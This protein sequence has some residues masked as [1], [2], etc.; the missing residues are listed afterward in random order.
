[1]EIESFVSYIKKKRDFSF[2]T[3]TF[4]RDFLIDYLKKQKISL[5]NLNEKDKKILIK[6]VRALLRKTLGSFYFNNF[7]KRSSLFIENKF[8]ELL[9]FHPSTRERYS[10]YPK[11][12]ELISSYSPKSILD[13]GCGINPLAIAEKKYTYYACDINRENL[14]IVSRFFRL[15]HVKGEV[16]Y[17]D[18]LHPSK[19]L[20]KTDICLIFKVLD[21]VFKKDRPAIK[22]LFSFLRSKIIFVS[23]STKTLSGKN[24]KIKRRFWFE[25]ILKDQNISFKI[26]E[27]PNELFYIINNSTC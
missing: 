24:M 13:I 4:I 12:K 10:F 18:V 6:E 22:N 21:S 14:T 2:L 19:A 3:D 7:K 27:L 15:N 20:P 25:K 16:F 9:L 8:D 1:M 17:Y 26:F 11:I 5:S 23:F